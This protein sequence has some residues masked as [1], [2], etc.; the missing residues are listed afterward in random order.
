M[1]ITQ[2][3]YFLEV[4]KT[5][6]ITSSAQRLHIA[7]PALSQSIHR[8]EKELGVKLFQRSGR[9]VVLT[10]Y[11]QFLQ[12]RLEPIMEKLDEIP[13]LIR[14]MS[15]LGNETIHLSVLAA[16]PMIMEAVIDYKKEHPDLNFQVLQYEQNDLYDIEITTKMFFQKNTESDKGQFICGEKI[17]LAVPV[18]SVKYKDR[19]CIT[20]SEVDGEDFISLLGSRQ[21][22]NIC[23]KFCKYAGF[24]PNVIFES[25]SANTVM[26][27]I[28]AGFGIGF[29]PERS[30]GMA[31]LSKVR[32]LEITDPVCYRDI[33]VTCKKNKENNESVEEFYRFLKRYFEERLS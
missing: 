25:D 9:N 1:E 31:D 2:I 6:H 12:E 28:A 26:D 8:L 29:W 3:R 4:A 11:G 15:K 18:N 22:R 23:D 14:I 5:Q 17:F 19:D 24:V 7:Q 32:L 21:F 16:T 10:E 30:W 33:V 20:L 13:E 27:M